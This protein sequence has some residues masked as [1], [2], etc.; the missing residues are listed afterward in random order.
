MKKQGE[1][2]ITDFNNKNPLLS[3]FRAST[4]LLVKSLLQLEEINPHQIKSRLKNKSSLETKIIKKSYKYNSLNEI[5]DLVGI[6]VIVYFEDEIDQ[7][8]DIIEK[9]FVI[10]RENSIDKRIIGEDKF[11]YR[12]LHYVASFKPNRLKLR[13]YSSFKKL[14]F[15]IQIRSILQHSWAEIEHDLGYKGENEKGIDQKIKESPS[16]VKIDKASLKSFLYKNSVI[17][18]I[19]DTIINS[20]PG[21]EK[22]K[23]D[24]DD[25]T[26]DKIINDL[27]KNNITT[28]SDLENYYLRNKKEFIKEQIEKFKEIGFAGFLEGATLNWML[29]EGKK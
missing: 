3:N 19:E 20:R 12:S 11:G 2:I 26:S 17:R 21:L 14:K 15:E 4:E 1:E 23:S 22:I 7:V 18:D 5:T 6:R 8:A 16:T 9:E 25:F 27:K 13:E 28:I 10:D 29:Y 24:R